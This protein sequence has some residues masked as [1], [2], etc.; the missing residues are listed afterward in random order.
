MNFLRN[1][2]LLLASLV[3]AV[4]GLGVATTATPAAHAASGPALT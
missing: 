1:G 2:T 3:L 4:G